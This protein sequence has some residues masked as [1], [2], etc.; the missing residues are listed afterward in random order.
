M[1]T[2]VGNPNFQVAGYAKLAVANCY[3]GVYGYFGQYFT[4]AYAIDT[5]GNVMRIQP[6]FFA[7]WKFL[8]HRTWS[9][10]AGDDAGC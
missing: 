8:R 1:I 10:G 6:V 3:P 9:G 7:L 5:N 4:I 2:T